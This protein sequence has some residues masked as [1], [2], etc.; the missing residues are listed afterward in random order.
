MKTFINLSCAIGALI[1]AAELNA[2]PITY[3]IEWTGSGVYTQAFN[4]VKFQVNLTGN[5]ANLVVDSAGNSIM[6]GMDGLLYGA[7]VVSVNFENQILGLQPVG[8]P[9]QSLIWGN[10][11]YS[12][13][14]DI[15]VLPFLLSTYDLISAIGPINLFGSEESLTVPNLSFGEAEDFTFLASAGEAGNINYV[16]GW[17]GTGVYS[18]AFN[19]VNF[20]VKLTGDTDNFM[21]DAA[22]N[23]F[24]EGLGGVISGDGVISDNVENQLISLQPLG[25]PGQSLIWGNSD[26]SSLLDVGR[27]PTEVSTYDLISAIGPVNLF[28]DEKSLT[29]PNISFGKAKDFTF[30]ANISPVTTVPEPATF[31]LLL[32]GVGGCFF[33]RKLRIRKLQLTYLGIHASQ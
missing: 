10:S 29:V 25:Y 22:G 19:D 3:T 1:L 33:V 2:T 21:T 26:Y 30:Q 12:S 20:Q 4:D 16:I 17:T 23:T 32:L 27:L 18:K 7:D 6:E 9:S 11:D 15:G 8:L 14:L 5:V 31:F 13:L 28:A 24:A